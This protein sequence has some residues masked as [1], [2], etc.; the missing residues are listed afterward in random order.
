MAPELKWYTV[1]IP[2]LE[3]GALDRRIQAL[4]QG[5]AEYRD[6]HIVQMAVVTDIGNHMHRNLGQME[7]E[8]EQ[9]R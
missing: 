9:K 5:E 8:L 3:G 1:N 2:V 4:C 7:R 6:Q